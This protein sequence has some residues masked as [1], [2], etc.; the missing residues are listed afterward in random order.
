MHILFLAGRFYPDI[1]GVEKH[2]LEISKRFIARGHT[3]TVVSEK[4]GENDVTLF[5]K[6]TGIKI[7]KIPVGKNEKQKKFII[8]K[9][10]WKNQSLITQADIIHCHD[11]FYW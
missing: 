6:Q 9:W 11:V 8:W 4:H 5:E 2:V 1:G 3:V 10:F 7:I